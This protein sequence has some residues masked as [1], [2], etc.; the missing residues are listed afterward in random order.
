M[1]AS[2]TWKLYPVNAV[3]ATDLQTGTTSLSHAVENNSLIEAYFKA[4]DPIRQKE[5]VEPHL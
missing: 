3:G 1:A 2:S 4:K 5:F